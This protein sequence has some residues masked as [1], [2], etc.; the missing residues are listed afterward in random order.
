MVIRQLASTPPAIHHHVLGFSQ[1]LHAH[2][3]PDPGALSRC[4][5]IAQ[6]IIPTFSPDR[7]KI[8]KTEPGGKYTDA[9]T[10]GT[11]EKATRHDGFGAGSHEE[12]QPTR[13]PVALIGGGLLRWGCEEGRTGAAEPQPPWAPDP[14]HQVRVDTI[15][16][17]PWS[18]S[19]SPRTSAP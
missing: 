17:V 4:L 19:R 3:P 15:Q 16:G 5:Q 6:R 8:W 18:R 10:T 2:R 9:H 14:A 13:P 12:Q 11:L 7:D 1:P